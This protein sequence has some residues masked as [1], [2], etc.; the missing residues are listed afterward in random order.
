ML[1][2]LN[3][4]LVAIAIIIIIFGGSLNK[5][6]SSAKLFYSLMFFIIIV[7]IINTFSSIQNLF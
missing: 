2:I 4:T 1:I 5:I 7:G 6:M 3:L